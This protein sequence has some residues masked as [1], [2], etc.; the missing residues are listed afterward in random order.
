MCTLFFFSSHSFTFLPFVS[1]LFRPLSSLADDSA[2][3]EP[4]LAQTS[5]VFQFEASSHHTQHTAELY[6][7]LPHKKKARSSANTPLK[8]QPLSRFNRSFGTNSDASRGSIRRAEGFSRLLAFTREQ[9]EI[10]TAGTNE[11]DVTQSLP[12]VGSSLLSSIDEGESDIVNVN[13]TSQ[14][15]VVIGDGEL[16]EMAVSD[17]VELD[18]GNSLVPARLED[19]NDFA[20]D[21]N[22]G[23]LALVEDTQESVNGL[24]ETEEKEVTDE[25]I[26]TQNIVDV[27]QE[28]TQVITDDDNSVQTNE[29]A[30]SIQETQESVLKDTEHVT[31]ATGVSEELSTFEQTNAAPEGQD[32]LLPTADSVEHD[33]KDTLE[34]TASTEPCSKAN[35][36]EKPVPTEPCS[37]ASQDEKPETDKQASSLVDNV[38]DIS[39]TTPS[40]AVVAS[41]GPGDARAIIFGGW[42]MRRLWA[43]VP[44]R[45]G[46]VAVG[47]VV[48]ASVVMWLGVFAS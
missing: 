48:A 10:E 25:V 19:K 8:P 13:G 39:P 40:Q 46:L 5:P 43:W 27:K 20:P 37:K 18:I 32:A 21:T 26:S 6:G 47:V 34:H 33:S 44:S 11:F 9:V 23:G 15:P 4:A 30:E 28:Q 38:L 3:S 36:D 31:Q 24:S 41:E 12:V 16:A 35:Q 14:G 7:T 2:G 22:V 45:A 29:I 42:I 17:G 1:F